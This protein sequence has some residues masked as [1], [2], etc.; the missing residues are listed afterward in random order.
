MV[1]MCRTVSCLTRIEPDESSDTSGTD[2]T[3]IEESDIED[4]CLWPDL[5]D[6]EDC[7]LYNVGSSVDNSLCMLEQD[8]WSYGHIVSMHDFDSEDSNEDI[9][10]NLDE[11]SVGRRMRIG[12]S[13]CVWCLSAG[14]SGRPSGGDIQGQCLLHR[15]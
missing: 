11:G 12:V 13:E 9:G 7:S 6:E 8:N 10:F 4:F 1:P 5:L 3:V 14:I 2:T 15:K